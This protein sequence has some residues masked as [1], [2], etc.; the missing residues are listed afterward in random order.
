M[1]T[2]NRKIYKLHCE[3]LDAVKELLTMVES[4]LKQLLSFDPAEMGT[5]IHNY[6]LTFSFLTGAYIENLYYQ[7]VYKPNF[8]LEDRTATFVESNEINLEE[9]WQILLE[10]SFKKGYNVNIYEDLSKELDVVTNLF[11]NELHKFLK[12]ELYNL[13]TVR[14]N[15]THGQFIH[16][17]NPARSS[18]H[19]V[20]QEVLDQQDLFTIKLRIKKFNLI[21]KIILELITTP[22]IF[23]KNFDIHFNIYDSL[24]HSYSADKYA[25]F[26]LQVRK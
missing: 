3:N 19:P 18:I 25:E 24:A 21:A 2:S 5:I 23:F 26:L 7:L 16:S 10:Y 14:E 1:D 22:D 8:T 4:D 11:Y 9:R 13:N 6:Q 20:S 15:V 12:V 17:F